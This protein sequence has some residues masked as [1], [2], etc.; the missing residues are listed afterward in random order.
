MR[1]DSS[2]R[3]P[4]KQAPLIFGRYQ[5][6]AKIGEGGAGQV[7]LARAKGE[8]GFERLFALKVIHWRADLERVGSTLQH[9][10]KIAAQ[11]HHRNVVGILDFGSY[12][13][14]Y[15]L[16]MEYVEGCTLSELQHRRQDARPPRLVVPIIIDALYGLHAA[17]ST[18]DETGAHAQLVHRDVSPQNLLIG[19]DG[20]CRVTDFGIAR[21]RNMMRTTRPNVV[22]G[23]PAYMSPEQIAGGELDRRSDIFS[24]GTV[25]WNALTGK[26]LF[27]GPSE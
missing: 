5:V 4:V 25:L 16:V 21:A 8:A 14:G 19:V 22:R 3:S 13:E 27:H 17:H 15:Y 9:E 26:K 2:S 6:I 18:T 20:A 23:K 12:P 7:F 11:V 1:L 24:V 10:M